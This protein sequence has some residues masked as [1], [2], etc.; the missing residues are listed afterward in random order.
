MELIYGRSFSKM[1]IALQPVREICI[2]SL[3]Y[4]NELEQDHIRQQELK[5]K[6]G[7]GNNLI[8]GTKNVSSLL[9]AMKHPKEDKAIVT[10]LTSEEYNK[11]VAKSTNHN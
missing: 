10:L 1:E 8:I 4:D 3:I 5:A 2:Q 11:Q 9:F 7:K 6:E